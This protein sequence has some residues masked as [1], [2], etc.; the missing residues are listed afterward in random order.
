MSSSISILPPKEG[1][2]AS[3]LHLLPCEIQHTGNVAVGRYFKPRPSAA[4]EA[5]SLQAAFRG[6]RLRGETVRPPAGYVGAVLQDTQQ[7][8][9]A[10]G[11]E[12]R[13]LHKTSFDE[14]TVWAH[15]D[16]VVTED[17][18]VFKCMRFAGIADVLHA[19]HAEPAAAEPA[20]GAVSPVA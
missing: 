5:G 9:V 16:A 17:E 14:F 18:P 15:D 20:A 13:W 10:D 3:S 1:A 2:V 11:E 7:A 8:S 12:R 19:D 6:R 4:G